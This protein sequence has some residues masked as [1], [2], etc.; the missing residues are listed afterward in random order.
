MPQ[1]HIRVSRRSPVVLAKAG[2]PHQASV[3]SEAEGIGSL[4]L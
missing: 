1:L 4:R 2:E 3:F